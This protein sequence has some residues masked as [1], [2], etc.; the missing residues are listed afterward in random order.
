M[1]GRRARIS[2][3][4]AHADV[5]ARAKREAEA[6]ILRVA[7]R[8]AVLNNADRLDPDEAA[9]PGRERAIRLGGEGT[10]DVLEFAPAVLGARLARFEALVE[11][12]IAASDPEAAAERERAAA[13][14]QCAHPTRSTEDGM[15]GFYV[16]A[17]LHVIARLDAIATHVARVLLELGVTGTDAE[18]RVQAVLILTDPQRACG[19]L[20][21]H[22]AWQH[23]SHD[24]VSLHAEAVPDLAAPTVDWEG[25]MPT[26]TL[27]LHLYAGTPAAREDGIARV[28]G[29]GHHTVAF[30][31]GAVKGAGQSRVSNYGPMTGFHHRIKTHGGWHVQ[32][33][34]PGIYVWRDAHGG[35]YLVDATGTR[36]IGQTPTI[37]PTRVEVSL[38]ATLELA[39]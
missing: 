6:E 39:A 28:E 16:R 27:F 13:M 24:A 31:H 25:L 17:P 32:Q 35:T 15:R 18:R 22:A 36:R 10:P 38:R 2:Q 5:V 9:R 26:V 20:E 30:R 21:K 8:H 1:S 3:V 12:A 11:G 4:L 33:P 34:F 37:Q 19:L 14:R 7:V 23:R 29:H